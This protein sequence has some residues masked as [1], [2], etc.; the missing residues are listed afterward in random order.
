M[1]HRELSGRQP[2]LHRLGQFQKPQKIRDRRSLF[3][4]AARDFLLRQ[5]ELVVQ[6]MVGV[7]LFDR[8]EVLALNV[9]DEGDL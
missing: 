7:R 2:P 6:L 1:T 4:D 9:L 3:A 5:A 8:V